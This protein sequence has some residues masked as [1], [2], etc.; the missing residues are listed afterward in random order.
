MDLRFLGLLCCLVLAGCIAAPQGGQ[1]QGSQ[2]QGPNQTANTT[3]GNTVAPKGSSD[4]NPSGNA[5]SGTQPAQPADCS[6]NTPPTLSIG[7]EVRGPDYL[8]L[9]LYGKDADNDTLEY[10]LNVTDPDGNPI[11]TVSQNPD[12]TFIWTYTTGFAR[13]VNVEATASD[14][15]GGQACSTVTANETIQAV[16]HN[17]EGNVTG[18]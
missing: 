12:K 11:G 8:H 10:G 13:Y 17:T 7:Y 2:M 16:I 1:A 18:A 9:I 3:P 15:R 6:G 14:I 4:M 5:S